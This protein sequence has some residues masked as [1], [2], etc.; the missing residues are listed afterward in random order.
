MATGRSSVTAIALLETALFGAILA[1]SLFGAAGTFAWPAAWAVLAAFAAF[2]AAGLLLLPADLVAERSR[3]PADF[4]GADLVVAGGALVLLYPASFVACGLDV[5]AHGPS[6][7]AAL[8]A[9]AFCV[10]VAGYALS[11]WAARVNRFFA[12]VVRVQRERGH[13]VVSSGPYAVLRHPG[14]AGAVAA[15]LA[16]PL[17]LG[18]PWGV[19]PAVLGAGFVVLRIQGEERVL[20]EGL[21][22]YAAY[23]ARVRWRL[24]P[25]VW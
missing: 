5:R 3:L 18:S 21:P 19:A 7:P 12:A 24:L 4:R 20:R 17:A 22:G 14:Y 1:A 6:F 25:G 15:H 8:R 11:L 10:F 2:S 16:L 9:V 13:H 23:A